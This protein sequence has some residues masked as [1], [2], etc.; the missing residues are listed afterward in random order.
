MTTAI[1]NLKSEYHRVE[2][3]IEDTRNTTSDYSDGLDAQLNSIF[4]EIVS[5]GDLTVDEAVAILNI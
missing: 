3:K 1:K 2:A 5:Q 4:T